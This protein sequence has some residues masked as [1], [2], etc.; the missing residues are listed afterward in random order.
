MISYDLSH[1]KACAFDVDGVL[2]RITVSLDDNGIPR[3]SANI[4]DGYAIQLAMKRGLRIA[5]ITGARVESITDR[6]LQMGVED[7]YL[8]ASLKAEIFETF[9]NRHDLQPDEVLYMGDDIPDY[10][11]LQLCGLPCCPAD[12]AWEVKSICNYISPFAGGE[13]CVRDVLEQI[14][15]AQGKWMNDE[16]AYGW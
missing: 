10:P 11:V 5:I 7:I 13:G 15:K 16:E 8:G 3:R 2:S 6:Y 14:L 1:I 12:A 9:C 4:R